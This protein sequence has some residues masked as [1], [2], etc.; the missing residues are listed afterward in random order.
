VAGFVHYKN[1]T[2]VNH[3]VSLFYIPGLGVIDEPLS[4][5]PA[6]R[7]CRTGPPVYIGW[8]T[9]SIL[10]SMAGRYSNSA[11][12]AQLTTVCPK[13]TAMVFSYFFVN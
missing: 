8:N 3:D 10:C 9:M 6:Q 4:A 13:L 1:N 7:S 5:K 12:Q 11:E 2:A